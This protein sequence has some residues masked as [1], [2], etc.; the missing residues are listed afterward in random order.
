[1]K[2][3]C[4]CIVFALLCLSLAFAQDAAPAAAQGNPDN[5]IKGAFPVKLQKGLDSKKAKEGDPVVCQTV[6][7]LRSRSGFM[8]P[9]GTKVIGHVTKSEARSKGGSESA[10][11]IA[12]DKIQLGQGENIDIK[13]TLQAV[14]PSLGGE[15]LD[16][17]AGP[18]QLAARGTAGSSAPPGGS[19]QI[20]GP[21][22]GTPILRPTSQGV[23]GIKNM[24]MS[25]D[26]VITSSGKEVKLENG[27]QLLVRAEFEIPAHSH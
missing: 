20:A 24:E 5:Q 6:G 17:S 9:T 18:P 2:R 16:T 26:G 3:W 11:G 15:A 27:T 23:L 13:G 14:A 7:V 4:G 25:S 8:I 19:V 10:L 22:S 12:F 21:N 1:M